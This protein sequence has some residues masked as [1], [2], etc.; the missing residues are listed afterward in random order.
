MAQQNRGAG[1]TSFKAQSADLSL[2]FSTHSSV[3]PFSTPYLFPILDNNPADWLKSKC[4]TTLIESS[5]CCIDIAGGPF[6]ASSVSYMSCFVHPSLCVSLEPHPRAHEQ[7]KIS[8]TRTNPSLLFVF[9]LVL[10]RRRR[11]WSILEDTY[12]LLFLIS[13]YLTVLLYTTNQPTITSTE[14]PPCHTV[15][16][17]T[18]HQANR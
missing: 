12:W 9:L 5:G 18:T 10:H 16:T 1:W 8:A 17:T 11:L 4:V 3:C 6:C 15:T 14:P 2:I 13:F 7:R